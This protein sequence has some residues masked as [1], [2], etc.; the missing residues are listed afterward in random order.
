MAGVVDPTHGVGKAAKGAKAAGKAAKT[1]KVLARETAAE[2]L[3]AKAA[4]T[5]SEVFGVPLAEV[6]MRAENS[7]EL[8]GD[9]AARMLRGAACDPG[10]R[11]SPPPGAR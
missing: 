6:T 11:L 9:D 7:I 10:R 2:E 5:A 4:R 8:A 3:A 1:A